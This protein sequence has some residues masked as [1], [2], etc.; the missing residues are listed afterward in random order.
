VDPTTQIRQLSNSTR[1]T[2]CLHPST[3]RIA[4]L[5]YLIVGVFGGLAVGYATPKVYVADEAATTAENVL[6]N[7][8]LVRFSV[9][10]DLFQMDMHH[11]GFLIAQIFFGLWLVPLA[12]SPTRQGRFRKRWGSC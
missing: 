11:Y 1:R 8:A 4:G 12:I 7:S 2:S 10:A 5:L 3:S 9:K 6:A